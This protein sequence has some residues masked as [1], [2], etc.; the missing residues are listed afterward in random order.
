MAKSYSLARY[1]TEA[2]KE[3]FVI[4]LGDGEQIVI[5]QPSGADLLEVEKAKTSEEVL[6]ILCGKDYDRLLEIVK[7]EDAGVLKAIS[8]DLRDHF[9]L[10]ASE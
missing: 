3:P 2:K 8:R 9:R 5:P 1:R 7:G 6:Q 10:A 4:D